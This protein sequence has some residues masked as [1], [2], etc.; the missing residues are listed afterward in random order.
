MQEISDE[1]IV[2]AVQGGDV[3]AFGE[4]ISRYEDKL[5]RYARKFLSYEEDIE[6]LVQDV[7]IKTYTNI[8]SF[9]T[10]LR[11]SPWIYR[12]AHN[13]FV[14]ELKRKHAGGFS[15]FSIDEILPFLPAQETADSDTL[16]AELRKE[17]DTLLRELPPKYREVIVLHYLEELSYQEISDIL[18]IPVTTVGVRLTR[19]RQKLQE[20]YITQHHE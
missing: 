15:L 7:F 18:Q 1:T 9:D 17:I 6:D 13:T 14:N 10:S 16:N 4:L 5:K 20:L 3:D 8:R 11:F 19:S 2:K 12:I